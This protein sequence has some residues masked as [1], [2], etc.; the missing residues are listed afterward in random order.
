MSLLSHST[1]S[2]GSPLPATPQQAGSS[3]VSDVEL[4]TQFLK[5]RNES[6]FAALVERYGRLVFAV[7]LR[8]VRDRHSAEDVTQA[9]FFLLAQNAKKIRRREALSSW[10]HGVAIR[11]AKKALKRRTREQVSD[12]VT[13]L[14]ADEKSFAEIHSTFEQQV[15]D[16]ELQQLPSQYRE[17]LVL[18]FLQG[19]TYAETAQLL[20]VSIGAIEGRMKRGKR[21]LHL[22]LTK[23][24]VG[25]SAVLAALCWSQEAAAATLGPEFVQMISVNGIA[26]F[27]GT[28]FAPTCSPE[29]VYL[30]GKEVTMFTTTKIVLLAC[31]LAIA[32]GAGWLTH[33]GFADDGKGSNGA[34]GSEVGT[35]VDGAGQS[36]SNAEVT[37][38]VP[39]SNSGNQ[40]GLEGGGGVG[41]GGEDAPIDREH[42]ALQDVA[43]SI[44]E[45]QIILTLP[46]S[47][48]Q[49]DSLVN[50]LKKAQAELLRAHEVLAKQNPPRRPSGGSGME[51]MMEL[52]GRPSQRKVTGDLITVEKKT[53]PQIEKITKALDEITN[54]EFPG[55][56]LGDV[57]DYISNQHNIPIMIDRA[58][59]GNEGRSS[60]DE[61]EL[62]L[63]GVP[64][65]DAL[66]LLLEP[67]ELTY[68]TENGV[69]K[70][71][72]EAKASYTLETR[73]YDVRPLNVE[74]PEALADVIIH[75]TG[76]LWY[77]VDQEGGDISFFNGSLVIR[78]T[79]RVHGEIET[80]L[81]QLARQFQSAS[82]NPQ[83]PAK[84][85]PKP[86]KPQQG[87]GAAAEK[88]AGTG[89]GGYF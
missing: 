46:L 4:L 13:E 80:L 89:G 12:V 29:A 81:N 11:L 32:T 61:V 18:H 31:G 59:L 43:K 25:L 63:S 57:V 64:L 86:E 51:S 68:I 75:S 9:T 85:R 27:Q 45:A 78:T 55:N 6:A 1:E 8:I 28:A 73:V 71:T 47:D 40:L 62:I 87:G 48:Q 5:L 20:G 83:W 34:G 82:E 69:M 39:S 79:Q 30:A 74:D 66:D 70:I 23:R 38:A 2:N 88:A 19:K 44:R 77:E 37:Q 16:E 17:P 41:F 36:E 22:R 54:V 7:S 76:D 49:K 24:G 26:A 10:L 65:H 84:K 42:Q 50:Q 3:L 33:A 72:T 58:E 52:G 15:L 35:V 67:L 56:P 14:E 53:S 60:D 21:E